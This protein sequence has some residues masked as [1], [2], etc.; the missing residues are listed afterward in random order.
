MGTK[1]L[2]PADNLKNYYQK[3]KKVSCFP[4]SLFC[5][6]GVPMPA[7]RIVSKTRYVIFFPCPISYSLSAES[8]PYPEVLSSQLIKPGAA[9]QQTP[10]I[11][12]PIPSLTVEF[13]L[14]QYTKYLNV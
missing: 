4:G 12:F 13:K 6:D 2:S 3:Q 14:M 9:Q 1:V 7:I 5:A 10:D 11:A 8:S